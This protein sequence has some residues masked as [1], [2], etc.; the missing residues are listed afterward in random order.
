MLGLH[1]CSRA[2]LV[3]ER[4]LVSSGGA[5]ASGCRGFPCYRLQGAQASVVEVHGLNCLQHVGSSRP[6]D[7][8]RVLCIG[9]QILNHWTTREVLHDLIFT[10]EQYAVAQITVTSLVLSPPTSPVIR[11]VLPILAFLFHNRTE[12]VPAPGTLHA[13]FPVLRSPHGPPC[14]HSAFSPMGTFSKWSYCPGPCPSHHQPLF[15]S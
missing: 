12:L 15:S 4:G 6:R 3:A 14:P 8:T 11:D 5:R 7:R 2:Y 13:L 10:P 1:C 9:R